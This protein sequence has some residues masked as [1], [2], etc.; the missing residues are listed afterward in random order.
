MCQVNES[1]ADLEK[2]NDS[3][4]PQKLLV[5]TYKIVRTTDVVLNGTTYTHTQ[6]SRKGQDNGLIL[7]SSGVLNI[8]NYYRR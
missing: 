7:N 6:S 2:L 8:T 5:S 4:P 1:N 3:I